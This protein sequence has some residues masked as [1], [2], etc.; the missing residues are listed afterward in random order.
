MPGAQDVNSR[1]VERAPGLPP[2]F[3]AAAP[4]PAGS[5]SI[6]YWIA[7]ADFAISRKV[8]FWILPVEVFGSS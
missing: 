1:K 3:P 2:I 6:G 5:V 7:L 4:P 8:N